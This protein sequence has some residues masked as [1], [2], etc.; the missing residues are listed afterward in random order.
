M[1]KKTGSERKGRNDVN[2]P[3]HLSAP[4]LLWIDDGGCGAHKKNWPPSSHNCIRKQ[5]I[6]KRICFVDNMHARQTELFESFLLSL[7]SVFWGLIR[8]SSAYYPLSMFKLVYIVCFQVKCHNVTTEQVETHARLQ[9][10]LVDIHT[11]ISI[12]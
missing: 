9:T 6:C 1:Q 10:F 12:A 8:F 4:T 3:Y 5:Q 7:F 11:L 2:P